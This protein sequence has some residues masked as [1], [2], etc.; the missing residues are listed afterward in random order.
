MAKGC[1]FD[2]ESL[3]NH[4]FHHAGI[5]LG[6]VSP[7]GRWLKVNPS[8]CSI[9]GYSEEELLER[10]FQSMTHPEDLEAD[11]VYVNRVLLGEMNRYQ[12]EKR[13]IHKNGD[14]IWVYITVSLVRDERGKPLFFIS[15]VQDITA[16]KR[17]ERL[18][19]ESNER[20]K[21]LFEQHPDLVFAVSLEGKLLK[22]NA[23]CEKVTGYTAQE[24]L[25]S[26]SIVD[27]DDLPRLKDCVELA[28]QGVPQDYE[29][30]IVH[31]AG[32]K[33]ALRVTNFPIIVDGRMIGIYGIAKDVSEYKRKSEKLKKIRALYNLIA[34]NAQDIITI[35]DTAGICKYISPTVRTLLGYAPEEIVG[36]LSSD[37]WHPEDVQRLERS[38][39]LKY[40]DGDLI[41]C[42][43]R[44]KDGRYIWFE[45][46]VKMIRSEEGEVTS[47]LGVGRDISERVQ[48]VEGY[49]RI[50]EDSPETVVISRNNQWVYVN[51]A[52]MKLFGCASKAE[53]LSKPSLEYVVP[54]LRQAVKERMARVAGGETAELME[55]RL[56]R[57]D[58]T[59]IHVESISIPTVFNGEPATHTIIRDITERKKTQELLINSEKLSVAGQLAAGIAHEIRNP[60]TA[61]KGFLKLMAAGQPARQNYLDVISEEMNRIED[62]LSELLLLAKPQSLKQEAVNLRTLL[63]QTVTLLGTQAI[64]NNI[65]IETQFDPALP[66]IECDE[67][68]LK[69]VFINFIKNAIEAMPGGGNIWV[70]ARAETDGR[71]HIY[72][73]DNGCGIPEDKLKRLGEPFFTTKEKGTGLGLMVSR[74][75]IENHGGDVTIASEVGKGTT[76]EVTLPL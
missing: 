36:K 76:V 73:K 35:T 55:Q 42:R 22:I 14:P 6:L 38:D 26:T 3:F 20:Y 54:E 23:A 45:T 5:G 46:T 12:L 67:N 21:S 33:V 71:L 70:Q 37:F 58:G 52:G 49:R 51:A 27:P 4:T 66:E 25:H 10:R 44:H 34:D 69:Q 8:L 50:V 28:F 72:V 9:V 43:V 29:I 61:I 17:A 74:R 57:L 47:Y 75:I 41:S 1:S 56:L 15:E 60:L 48:M 59:M 31:K 16:K 24:L 65:A 18:L 63:E 62:I 13:Y 64:M 30:S 40:A 68:Q 32:H 53:A 2:I 39:F 11:I 7:E 19:Q